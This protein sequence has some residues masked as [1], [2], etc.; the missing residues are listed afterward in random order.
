MSARE[1]EEIDVHDYGICKIVEKSNAIAYLVEEEDGS[2]Y[3]Y[4][5]PDFNSD[6]ILAERFVKFIKER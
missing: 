4:L 5:N 6:K 2:I 1:G 3:W